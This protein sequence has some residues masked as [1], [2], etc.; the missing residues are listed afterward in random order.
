MTNTPCVSSVIQKSFLF[1]S[2][3]KSSNNESFN[4]ELLASDIIK[5]YFKGIN[6]LNNQHINGFDKNEDDFD[7]TPIID[8]KYVDL[9]SFRVFE[10]K[11]KF[12]LLHLNIAS[13]SLHKEELENVFTMLNFKFDVIGITE[14]KIK[15]CIVP[16][17]DVSIKGYQHFFTPTESNKGGVILYIAEQHCGYFI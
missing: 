8:C 4:K 12:S 14:T 7:I 17:Y 9:N 3:S 5:M 13:L 11:N 15:K 6:D 10:D 2:G 16:D 1:Y